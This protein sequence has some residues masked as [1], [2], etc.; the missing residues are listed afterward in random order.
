LSLRCCWSCCCVVGGVGGNVSVDVFGDIVGD[1]KKI[2][3]ADK[4]AA[5]TVPASND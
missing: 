1:V 2:D 5:D 4:S 3:D